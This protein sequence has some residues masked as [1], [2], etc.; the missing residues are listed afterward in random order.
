VVLG[1]QLELA[2]EHLGRDGVRGFRLAL[3]QQ[4]GGLSRRNRTIST[5]HQHRARADREES[6]AP[7][8]FLDQ[9]GRERSDDGSARRGAHGNRRDADRTPALGQPVAGQRDRSGVGGAKAQPA[10]EPPGGH[11]PH[12][13]R[14]AGPHG[15]PRKDHRSDRQRPAAADPVSE[16]A[17]APRPE[18]E[19]DQRR[20][21]GYAESAVVGGEFLDDDR[22]DDAQQLGIHPVRDQHQHADREGHHRERLERCARDRFAE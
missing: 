16:P 21:H 13:G 14:K 8:E 22:H 18:A 3:G 11:L 19:A 2:V 10:H 17:A 20:H 9:G 6:A 5:H 7:A 15:G 4:V 1:D 12:V